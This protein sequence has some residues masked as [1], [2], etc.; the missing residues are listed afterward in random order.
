MLRST[1]L[2]SRYWLNFKS[3]MTD[4]QSVE[5]AISLFVRIDAFFSLNNESKDC[6]FLNK[7]KRC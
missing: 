2:R 5:F 6:L 4:L 1:V 7:E 3:I